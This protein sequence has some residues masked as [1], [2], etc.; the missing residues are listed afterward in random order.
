[1]SARRVDLAIAGSGFGGS[2]LARIAARLGLRVALLERGRHPRFALG[3][4]T[5]P[6]SNLVLAQLAGRYQLPDLLARAS[7]GAWKRA[8]PELPV[9]KK[10]GFT[11]LGHA[12]GRPV[13]DAPDGVLMVAASDRD[14]VAD[15]QWLRADLDAWLAGVAAREVATAG[16]LAAEGCELAL[17]SAGGPVR[18]RVTTGDEAFAVEADLLVDATGDGGFLSRELGLAE[19][20]TPP[21][22]ST[23]SVYGHL[24]GVERLTPLLADLGHRVGLHPYESDDA[25][26]HHVF[27]GGWCWHLRFDGGRVSVG[28]VLDHASFPLEEGA[29]PEALF[30]SL[31]ARYPLLDALYRDARPVFPFRLAP[32]L[33]RR[34]AA[35]YG[36]AWALLPHAA[37]FVDPLLSGGLPHT[38]LAVERL[39]ALL[40]RGT[41][42]SGLADDLARYGEEVL[43][44]TK[45]L[46]L[47]V[48]GCRRAFGRFDLFAAFVMHYFVAAASLETARR[49]GEAL[50]P[51]PGFLRMREPAFRAALDLGLADLDAALAAPSAAGGDLLARMSERLAPWDA[52]GFC[53]PAS[54][55]LHASG[56]RPPFSASR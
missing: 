9:G 15:T 29:D 38:L 24:D 20:D 14:E 50:D 51:D 39:T 13:A 41:R 44:E 46:T 47:L 4:S 54:G 43:E 33:H 18:L 22:L 35:A 7:Y 28:F 34:L 56:A 52:E 48:A 5:T 19:E 30:R 31:A 6:L 25:A 10:R 42:R 16:G 55:G 53:D 23:W 12:E 8:T 32:R 1:M 27:D 21:R 49:R 45:G 40:S 2:L 11:F 36:P 17:E 3:E 26:V 37:G